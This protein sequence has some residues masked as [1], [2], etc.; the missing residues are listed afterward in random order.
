[1]K[2]EDESHMLLLP[3]NRNLGGHSRLLKKQTNKQRITKR[4]H[5]SGISLV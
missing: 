4:R 1:M 5:G 2:H 3:G